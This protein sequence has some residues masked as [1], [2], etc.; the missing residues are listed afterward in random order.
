VLTKENAFY[1]NVMSEIDKKKINRVS[2]SLIKK[3][4]LIETAIFKL[5]L[6]NFFVNT[7]IV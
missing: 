7:N 2:R 1:S 6:K 4:D 5:E 3:I